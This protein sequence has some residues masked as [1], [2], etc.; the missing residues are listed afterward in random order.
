MKI[1]R[2]LQV[3]L[4]S[5]LGGTEAFVMNLYRHID[6]QKIQFDFLVD[7]DKELPF[8]D[9][10]LAMGGRIFH[11]Y[12]YL[13]EKNKPDY[14]SP[15]QFFL[16]HQDIDVVHLNVQELNTL[17]RVLQAAQKVGIQTRILHSH[18][19]GYMYERKLKHRIYEMYARMKLKTLV[20]HRFACSDAAAEFLF[21]GAGKYIVIPN[22]IDVTKFA[23]SSEI[24]QML[25]KKLD[26][27]DDDILL[28]FVGS[29]NY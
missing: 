13:K 9:E 27:C 26:V 19:A 11:E 6:R 2:V 1:L 25:R 15:Q 12:Y 17:I 22:A 5:N 16:K 28:G 29:F 24:R 18:N 8:E 3:G 20:T 21:R 14:I 10:I 23:F 7:H 4:T